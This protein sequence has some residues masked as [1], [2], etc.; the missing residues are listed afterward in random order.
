M[1]NYMA[2]AALLAA[3]VVA[4]SLAITPALCAQASGSLRAV[5]RVDAPPQGRR[6]LAT[7]A[8]LL[9]DWVQQREG[10]LVR[11]T[12]LARIALRPA[13]APGNPAERGARVP[14][15]VIDIEYLRN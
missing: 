4:G 14:R 12:S 5:A 2:Q 7:V 11:R 3:G 15:L 10:L 1:Q 8:M 13:D 9:P 6:T